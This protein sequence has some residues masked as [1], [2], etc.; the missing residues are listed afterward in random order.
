MSTMRINL[1]L[2]PEF[3]PFTASPLEFVSHI[4]RVTFSNH[5]L[6]RSTKYGSI[7]K[8]RIHIAMRYNSVDSRVTETTSQNYSQPIAPI[9]LLLT[10]KEN[11]PI[12]RECPYVRII[13]RP[14]WL[15]S[16]RGISLKFLPFLCTNVQML[17]A[18]THTRHQSP[19]SLNRRLT[20]SECTN[21]S[22]KTLQV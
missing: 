20:N 12:V 1:I 16:T 22:G 17:I 7:F 15:Y 6:K 2:S 5:C 21:P 8:V 9:Q 19:T 3:P 11:S 10:R 4:F 18:A 13:G 14:S